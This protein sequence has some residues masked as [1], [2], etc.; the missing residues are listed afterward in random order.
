MS[1]GL[2]AGMLLLGSLGC[3]CVGIEQ[4]AQTGGQVLFVDGRVVERGL[5]EQ[6]IPV[7]Y[8]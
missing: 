4:A 3:G 1:I 5:V 2:R 6:D 7:S 8:I